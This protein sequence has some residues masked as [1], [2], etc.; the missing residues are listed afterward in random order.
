MILYS[1]D[2]NYTTICY[3]LIE[4]NCRRPEGRR[5]TA[6]AHTQTHA[7]AYEHACVSRDCYTGKNSTLQVMVQEV[8]PSDHMDA[9]AEM[10]LYRRVC[11]V[12]VVAC[13]VLLLHV[14]V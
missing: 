6:L 4:L 7:Q 3:K 8:L 13:L 12:C 5:F 14:V 9:T 1:T 11:D 10:Q 2:C